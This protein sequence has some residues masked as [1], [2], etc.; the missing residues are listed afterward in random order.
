MA[1]IRFR[2]PNSPDSFW[3]Q[4]EYD[5]RAYRDNEEDFID[6][7]IEEGER[8][9]KRRREL[10][11]LAARMAGAAAVC[12]LIALFMWYLNSHR[13]YST[14]SSE[15]IFEMTLQDDIGCIALGSNL[16][17]YSQDGASC[18]NTRGEMV[19]SLSYEMQSPI[20]AKAGN[21]LAIGDDGGSMIYLQSD[22]EILGTINTNLP[23]RELCV[24]ESGRVAAVLA[25]TDIN[26]VYLFNSAGETIAYIKTTMGQSGY[27]VSLALS[28]GGELLCVSHLVADS[29]GIGSS[30][31]FYN[32]GSVGQNYAENN[33][34]GFNYDDEIF[35]FLYYINDST[36][37]AVSDARIVFF[38]GKEIPQSSSNAL[39]TENLEGVFCGGEYVAL[40]FPDSTGTEDYSLQ[41][42]D[43]S[44]NRTT[45][46][47]FSMAFTGIEIAGERIYISND[48][49]LLIYTAS[50]QL[51]Y[52]GELPSAAR[53]VI[54]TGK[55]ANRVFLL[56]EEGIERVT[57]Q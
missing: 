18:L 35:P 12:G 49:E 25:D 48:T 43:S 19:W 6:E 54:S 16:V 5:D 44:G 1:V 20:I 3:Q 45:T 23:I 26:W 52:D 4:D 37:A 24:S 21:L 15:V 30:V 2:N 36:C 29:S 32:F 38:S 11:R 42:Y 31:A 55:S 8:L 33:V 46:I 13:V 22:S 51:R 27:P 10:L 7:R 17:Y 41:V 50:G 56:T 40:L 14:A 39:F 9:R 57:L 34:S 47:A 53:E 28:P